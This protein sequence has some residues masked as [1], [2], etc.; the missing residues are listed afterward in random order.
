MYRVNAFDSSFLSHCDQRE[1]NHGGQHIKGEGKERGG[2]A[3]KPG[4]GERLRGKETSTYIS[5]IDSKEPQQD[6]EVQTR[7]RGRKI[8]R[9]GN[10]DERNQ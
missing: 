4:K 7:G 9:K 3:R 2:K 10:K 8:R 5:T 1:K 6:Q